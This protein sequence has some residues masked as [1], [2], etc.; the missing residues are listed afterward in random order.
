MA[1]ILIAENRVRVNGTH[2]NVATAGAGSPVL[3]MHGFP[4]TWRVW[5]DIIPALG[6]THRVIAPDLRG[7]GRSDRADSGYHA[8]ELAED[9]AFLLDALDEPNAAVVAIDAGAPPAFFLG[10]EHPDR[11][12]RL[13]LM[14]STI[15]L[16]PGAEEFFRAGP[17][18]WF[19][20]HS[21]PGFAEKVLAGHEADYV[22]FFLRIGMA[23]KRVDAAVRDAFVDAYSDSDSL[24]CAFEYYRAMPANTDRINEATSRL[25]LTMPTMAIGGQVVGDAT[26]RQLRP[27]TDDL[28]SHTI[29]RS[30]HI[31]P[32]DAP[33]ELLS[34]IQPFL[35]ATP[36]E[37]SEP[38]SEDNVDAQSWRA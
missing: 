6:R 19:G 31:I 37:V 22:D 25:R 1:S 7:L 30:G 26:W 29:A 8:H 33:D 28:R 17:P 9:M 12:S 34:L 15:G 13:V 32:L 36:A 18:W 16:L 24:R 38:P 14:E 20:F 4:H 27:V 2:L 3:V 10:L 11:V 5:N 21:I 35:D 23:S